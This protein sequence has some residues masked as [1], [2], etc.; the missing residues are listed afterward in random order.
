VPY[1]ATLRLSDPR[2]M[3][4][5]VVFTQMTIRY[6]TSKRMRWLSRVT[7]A[8]KLFDGAPDYFFKIS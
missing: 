1:P 6:T 7:V 4:R 5:H 3:G 8:Y 2:R